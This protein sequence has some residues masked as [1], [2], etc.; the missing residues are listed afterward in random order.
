MA[1]PLAVFR[2]VNVDATKDLARQAAR[3]GVHRFVFVSSIKV[4]G[5]MTQYA[6]FKAS[7]VPAPL[8]A[9]GQSKLEAELALQQ[10]SRET[11]LEVVIVRP[12][13]VYGPG[14]GANFLRLMQL[15]QKGIPLPLGAIHNLRSLV[16]LDNLVDLLIVCAENLAAAGR[17]FLVSDDHDVSTPELVRMLATAM[18][19]RARLV[20]VPVGC[21]AAGAALL[22][23]SAAADRLLGSLQVDIRETRSVL[24]WEPVVSTEEAIGATVAHFL[25][26]A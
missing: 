3:H 24:G 2:T 16:A 8:D 12:P 13:L 18:G 25:S 22:G 17:T 21:L 5:E 10:I 6:S 19:R 14:V 20:P 9:Y 4:N 23:K 1:D 7:D 26:R 11:G 15:V